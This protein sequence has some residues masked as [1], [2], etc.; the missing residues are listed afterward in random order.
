M[1]RQ[2][3][4]TCASHGVQPPTFV[5]QHLVESL[6]S[7]RAIGFW[8]SREDDSDRPD[9]WCSA[10][11]EQLASTNQQWTAE[12]VQFARPKLLCGSCYDLAYQIN[13]GEVRP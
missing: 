8:W 5:C 4:V 1:A 9:A 2:A 13:G 7:R 12:T 11:K 10:C 3:T 6:D